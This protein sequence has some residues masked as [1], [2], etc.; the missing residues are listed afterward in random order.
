MPRRGLAF[1]S[2]A[3]QVRFTANLRTLSQT[4]PA[5]PG[6]SY[7]FLFP[8][9]G[10]AVGELDSSDVSRLWVPEVRHIGDPISAPGS[11]LTPR[12]FGPLSFETSS[13]YWRAIDRH[14]T[15]AAWR[16][17]VRPNGAFSGR[18]QHFHGGASLVARL[19]QLEGLEV[20]SPFVFNKRLPKVCTTFSVGQGLA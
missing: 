16:R 2:G 4:N 1:L 17:L 3:Q 7:G 11:E 14:Q 19:S 6:P 5:Q 12:P 8:T 20:Q 15:F 13:S 10:G 9:R 18:H